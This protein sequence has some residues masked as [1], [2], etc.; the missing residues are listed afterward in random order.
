ML[1]IGAVSCDVPNDDPDGFSYAGYD[2]TIDVDG[3]AVS[4]EPG[5]TVPLG[6][7]GLEVEHQATVHET[8]YDFVERKTGIVVRRIR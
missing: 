7:S 6:D 3:E 1:T 4:P 2:V 5:T 8:L